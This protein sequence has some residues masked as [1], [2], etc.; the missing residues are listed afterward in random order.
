[1]LAGKVGPITFSGDTWSGRV[2]WYLFRAFVIVDASQLKGMA[3]GQFAD[4][5]A[6]VGLAQIKP[7]DSLGDAP[8]ILKL[9]NGVPQGAPAGMTDWDR[10]FLKAFYTERNRWHI[11]RAMVREIGH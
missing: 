8:T 1:M 3:L 7:A 4:Y 11:A 9:F 10:A 5:V 6:M 2:G